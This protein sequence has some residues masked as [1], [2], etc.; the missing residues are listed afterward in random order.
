MNPYIH[1]HA[2]RSIPGVGARTLL[3]ILEHFDTPQEAWESPLQAF[4]NIPEL[5]SKT[6]SAISEARRNFSLEKAMEELAR[7]DIRI[8]PFFDPEYPTLLREIPDFPPLLYVRGNFTGWN[9]KPLLT[10]IGSRRHTNYGKQVAE[11]FSIEA[12]QAGFVVV[13][14]LAFGIDSDAHQAAL[15]HHGETLAVLGS[16]IDDSHIT[17]QS[18]LALAKSVIQS[19]AL[20]SEYP[21]GSVANKGTFPARNRI[22]AGLSHGTLVVEAAEKS[23]TAITARLALD[24]NRDVFAVPGSIFSPLST[25]CHQLIRQGAKPVVSMA[26]IIEEYP[27]IM[28][29]RQKEPEARIAPKHLSL[30]ETLIWNIL[31]HETLHIDMILKRSTLGTTKTLAQLTLLELQGLAKNVGGQQYIRIT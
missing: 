10:I 27:H 6:L 23:G 22:M 12:V 8:L 4:Q 9:E 5:G 1:L 14:G 13:S 2:L 7:N 31:S 19:G 26:D 3:T 28:S 18:H 21:P 29:S 11:K 24:Y 15:H 16:G 25:G 17:P 20:L 30:D